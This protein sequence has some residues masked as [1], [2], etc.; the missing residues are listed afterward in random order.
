M[1]KRDI[2][3]FISEIKDYKKIALG[4]R[5]EQFL[6]MI[7]ASERSVYDI[8]KEINQGETNKGKPRN[9]NRKLPDFGS[10]HDDA[11]AY[12]DVHKGVKRLETLGLIEQNQ[13]EQKRSKRKVIQYKITSHGLFQDLLGFQG[14]QW[15]SYLDMPIQLVYKDD[16]IL[17]TLLY[18]FFEE[19]TVIRLTSVFGDWLFMDYLRKCCEGILDVNDYRMWLEKEGEGPQTHPIA[20]IQ[21]SDIDSLIRRE[22]DNLILQIVKLASNPTYKDQFPVYALIKDQ[23]LIP[24]LD[25]LSNDLHEGFKNIRNVVK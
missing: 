14:W 3:N 19:E 11:I 9:R 5:E 13:H 24:L 16:V 8:Y 18:Q 12:K 21:L 2:S 20:E 10:V 23:K 25:E 7:T 17:Q 22:L 1:Q 6:Q 15:P 4:Y